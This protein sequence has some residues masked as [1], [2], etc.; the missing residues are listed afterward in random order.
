MAVTQDYVNQL[1]REAAAQA[2]G[3]LSYSDVLNAARNMGIPESMVDAA[4]ST[5]VIT[6]GQTPAPA[7]Q[8]PEP[9]VQAPEPAQWDYNEYLDTIKKGGDYTQA[10]GNLAAQDPVMANN[11]QRIYQEIQNQQKLGTA[12][13]WAKG[14]T[15][16]KEAAAAD[17]ALRLAEAGVSSLGEVGQ[18]T[19]ETLD[20]EGGTYFNL[21]YFNK[22]TG[23]PLK[24]WDRLSQG[25][26]SGTK[27]NYRLDFTP[28]GIA[29]PYTAPKQSDWVEFR[30]GI[31]KPAAALFGSILI[32]PELSKFIGGS[33]GLTGP[34]LSGA[35]GATIGA[36]GTLLTGGS[37]EDA[38]RNALIAGA[39]GYGSGMLSGQG[40][41][42]ANMSAAEAADLAAGLNPDLAGDYSWLFDTPNVPIA[43]PSAAQGVPIVESPTDMFI[44][45]TAPINIPAI[46]GGATGGLLNAL[47][48]SPNLE[49]VSKR[50]VDTSVSVG[51]GVGGLLSSNIPTPS[52]TT[53]LPGTGQNLEVVGEKPKTTPPSVIPSMPITETPVIPPIT[54]T[55]IDIP[56]IVSENP[57]I[58]VNDLLKI[59]TSLGTIGAGSAIGSG[60]GKG[61][62]PFVPPTQTM[63]INTD[64]YYKAIQRY[65]NAYLP[66][67]PRDVA[68]P[69]RQWYSGAFNV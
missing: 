64:D 8:A 68:T 54:T 42:G 44:T 28:D 38:L 17:F 23:E 33:T 9:V 19:V 24:D 35:T 50:P 5:G 14:N 4:M 63:P 65:Y 30:E 41:G 31:L 49:V 2:G 39:A 18:R 58:S 46:V 53:D 67:M 11:A 12:D 7:V 51:G 21:E 69:L 32:A 3:T 48:S 62:V 16:S 57:N 61:N 34:A 40:V 36:G 47:T 59:I 45:G 25:T 6:G 1:V 29:V 22:A 15:A 52:V 60:G 37:L 56:K 20:G 66:E 55:P 10:I 13:S 26:N 27:L 43:M